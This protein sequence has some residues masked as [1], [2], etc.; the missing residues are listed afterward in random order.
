MVLQLTLER[1]LV[2]AAPQQPCPQPLGTRPLQSRCYE[3]MGR[4]T[5]QPHGQS[6]GSSY[7]P[8]ISLVSMALPAPA[9]P[10]QSV[11]TADRMIDLNDKRGPINAQLKAL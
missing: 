4:D 8:W 5:E 11:L 6:K 3:E 2:R 1:S 9:S 10:L 7:W